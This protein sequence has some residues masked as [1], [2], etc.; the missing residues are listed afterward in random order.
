MKVKHFWGF[1]LNQAVHS[2]NINLLFNRFKSI[3]YNYTRAY[4]LYDMITTFV[5]VEHV[6]FFRFYSIDYFKPPALPREKFQC[7][8]DHKCDNIYAH[9]FHYLYNF[10]RQ[11]V[12]RSARL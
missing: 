11:V 3:D 7:A 9:I 8:T 12:D 10:L 6:E 5:H 2:F 1:F 4:K